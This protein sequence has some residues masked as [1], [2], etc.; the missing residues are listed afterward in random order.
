MRRNQIKDC[1]VSSSR[2]DGEAIE[3]EDKEVVVVG[4]VVLVTHELLSL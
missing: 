3:G 1:M 2:S 4:D